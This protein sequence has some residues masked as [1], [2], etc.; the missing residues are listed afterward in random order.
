[1]I[2]KNQLTQNTVPT[3]EKIFCSVLKDPRFKYWP[4]LHDFYPVAKDNYIE[5]MEEE[6]LETYLLS[7]Q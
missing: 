5:S 7:Y 1:M 4:D 3:V 6:S 2:N